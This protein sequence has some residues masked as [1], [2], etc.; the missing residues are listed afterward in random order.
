MLY[1]EWC[2]DHRKAKRTTS[3]IACPL[4]LIEDNERLQAR[5]KEAEVERYRYREALEVIRD[6]PRFNNGVAACDI[7]REALGD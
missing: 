4:C 1:I 3:I 5:V 6:N 7:A 2:K